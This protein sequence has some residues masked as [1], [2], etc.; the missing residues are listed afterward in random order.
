MIGFMLY[1]SIPFLALVAI[2]IFALL[3]KV[4]KEAGKFYKVWE[5]L[6]GLSLIILIAWVITFVKVGFFS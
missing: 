6:F 2:L 5:V 4:N 1:L 3:R